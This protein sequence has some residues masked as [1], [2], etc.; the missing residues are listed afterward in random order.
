MARE[1]NLRDLG[2]GILRHLVSGVE[3][4]LQVK[5]WDDLEPHANE[6]VRDLFPQGQ[7]EV[8]PL[9]AVGYRVFE[10]YQNQR[11]QSLKALAQQKALELAAAK[12]EQSSNSD[13]IEVREG[14]PSNDNGFR[15]YR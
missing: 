5:V 10:S 14:G 13:D 12:F 4:D 8:S 9:V 3:R 6:F 2:L 1:G 15:V 7:C 11:A